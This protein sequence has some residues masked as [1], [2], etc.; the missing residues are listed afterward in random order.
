MLPNGKPYWE[1]V[2]DPNYIDPVEK[3]IND[4]EN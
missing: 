4:R 2:P 1:V 3:Y